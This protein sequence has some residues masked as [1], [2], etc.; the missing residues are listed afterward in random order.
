M[1]KRMVGYSPGV[2]SILNAAKEGR[3]QGILGLIGEVIDV[4]AGME[5]AIDVAAG[6]GL[7]NIVVERVEYA[8]QA[9]DFL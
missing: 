3:F 1:Q 9:I 4:P 5:L 6:G 8:R 2:K 7:Q